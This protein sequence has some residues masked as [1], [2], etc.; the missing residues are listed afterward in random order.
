MGPVLPL[1]DDAG[2]VLL[3][4]R[5]VLFASLLCLHFFSKT[6]IENQEPSA[7]FKRHVPLSKVKEPIKKFRVVGADS[8]LHLALDAPFWSGSQ[9]G[10]RGDF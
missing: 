10:P 7:I 4:L 9:K 2:D 8:V 5:R 3:A 1:R 6:R